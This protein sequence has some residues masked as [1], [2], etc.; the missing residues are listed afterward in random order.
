MD[1]RIGSVYNLSHTTKKQWHGDI[2]NYAN[3]DD[4]GIA[5]VNVK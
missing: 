1:A 2:S 3:D 5:H 4:D